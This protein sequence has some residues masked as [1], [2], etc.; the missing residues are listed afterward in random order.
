MKI[1]AELTGSVRDDKKIIDALHC[2]RITLLKYRN[3]LLATLQYIELFPYISSSVKRLVKSPKGYLINNGLVSYLTGIHDLSILKTTSTLGHR[4]ENWFLNDVQSWLDSQAEN[5]QIYFWRTS[6]GAEVDF[7]VTLGN[8]TVPFE[9][10]Y[11]S[12]IETKKLNN[13]KNFM[14]GSPEASIGV[15]CYSGPLAFDEE[16]RILYLPA[17]M[18]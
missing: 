15:F 11:S 13:L 14:K 9:V 17:W 3:Y 4:F 6:A 18:L 1:S 12:Q 8:Q 2:S 7:V 16:N 10:T 5:H